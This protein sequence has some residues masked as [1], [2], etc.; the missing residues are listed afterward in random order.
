MPSDS[1]R[2]PCRNKPKSAVGS[3]GAPLSPVISPNVVFEYHLDVVVRYIAGYPAQTPRQVYGK[4][5]G[6]HAKALEYYR[7]AK[8]ELGERLVEAWLYIYDA[9]GKKVIVGSW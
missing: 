6:T 9:N 5:V 1:I 3:W 4:V 8:S 7:K 2:I